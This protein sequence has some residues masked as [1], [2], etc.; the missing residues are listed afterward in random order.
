VSASTSDVLTAIKNIVQA[1]NGQ[2]TQDLGFHGTINATAI[3][4]PTSV[5]AKS[6]RVAKVS[7]TTAGTAPGMIYDSA[8]TTTTKPLYV[9]PAA[10][11]S[12]PY[13]VDMPVSFGIYVVPGAGQTLAVSYA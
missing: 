10:I 11:G 6:G 9:I 5:S 8:T 2:A 3:S 1:L 4:A 12:E 13:Q 7:V